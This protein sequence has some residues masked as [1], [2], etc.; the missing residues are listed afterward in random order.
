M[1]WLTSIIAFTV[2]A[3]P[4]FAVTV[5]P[6]RGG[7]RGIQAVTTRLGHSRASCQRAIPL[8]LAVPQPL[9]IQLTAEV[10]EDRN[11]ALQT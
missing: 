8:A 2:G 11:A 7:H 5:G 1:D 6:D 3:I 10:L 9:V 4:D